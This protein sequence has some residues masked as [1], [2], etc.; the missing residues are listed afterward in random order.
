M[1]A[2]DD[3]GYQSFFAGHSPVSRLQM[4]ALLRAI[5]RHTPS[6]TR[7]SIDIDLSPIAGDTGAQKALDAFLLQ[8]A[9]KWVLP[10]VQAA[11]SWQEQPLR[12][13]REGLCQQG[14][15]FGLPYVPTE[16][17]VPRLT[18]QYVDS[19][20][21]AL[22]NPKRSCVDPEQPA[23]QKGMPLSASALSHPNV[24]VF[25]GDME[26]LGRALDAKRPHAVVLG[27]IWGLDDRFDT[28]LGQRFG[29][30]LHAAAIAGAWQGERLGS[31]ISELLAQ[32]SI[33]ALIAVLLFYL[34]QAINR[35]CLSDPEKGTGGAYFEQFGK[36]V[37]MTA[38]MLLCLGVW[39]TAGACL[40]A[41]TG[42]WVSSLPVCTAVPII[43]VVIWN[44]GRAPIF[45]FKTARGA[46]ATT[47]RD[48]ILADIRSL[49]R[50]HRVL[51]DSGRSS[52]QEEAPDPWLLQPRWRIRFEW[53][54]SALSLLVQNVLPLISSAYL[55]YKAIQ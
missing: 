17:G 36:P 42:L 40:H 24:L 32:W 37:L 18:H 55:I 7:V 10:A 5:K 47:V 8:D 50:A 46:L 25:S 11:S 3:Q 2:I 45:M 51:S 22:L 53:A 29:V 39:V 16:F 27:G 23:V 15:Q 44:Y 54:A 49:C 1:I 38:F 48:P 35:L 14:L 19:L 28:P 26:A 31:R 9:G 12:K 52:E 20:G 34:S 21:D 41:W 30:Q 4:L 33:L 6:T 43:M 13:W